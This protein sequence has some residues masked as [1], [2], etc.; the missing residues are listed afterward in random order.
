[1]I[2]PKKN[3]KCLI[4][5][6]YQELN[7]A[8]Q[9]DHFSLSFI[10]QVLDSLAVKQYFSFLYRFTDYTQIRIALEDQDKATFTCPWG[11]FSYRVLPFGLC[12]APAT[13]QREVLGIFSDL[14]HD[15]VEI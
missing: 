15:F 13:F 5:V 2:V 12:D 8:T 3:G 10:D 7:K 14:T 11:T 9:K 6:D 1:M 4:C